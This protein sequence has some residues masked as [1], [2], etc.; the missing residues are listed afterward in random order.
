M[1]P[2]PPINKVYSLITQEE[3]Q[4]AIHLLPDSSSSSNSDVPVVFAARGNQNR[5]KS[6]KKERPLCTH[7]GIYVHTV[8]KCF[9]LH[10]Y[11]SGYKLRSKASSSS[12]NQLVTEVPPGMDIEKF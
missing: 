5:G 2:L 11:P 7:C 12:V 8:D 9:K 6:S 1:E 10:G 4:H 3:R